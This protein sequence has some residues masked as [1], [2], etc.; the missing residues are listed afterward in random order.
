MS[1]RRTE[2]TVPTQIA[3]WRPP[4]YA[5]DLAEHPPNVKVER[6][7]NLQFP[8]PF[9][10]HSPVSVPYHDQPRRWPIQEGVGRLVRRIGQTVAIRERKGERDSGDYQVL[11]YVWRGKGE[12]GRRKE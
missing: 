11:L 9:S 12:E 8:F 5:V 3:G 4:A 10:V 2:T 7:A 6:R 1:V